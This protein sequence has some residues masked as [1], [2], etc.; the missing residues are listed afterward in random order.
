MFLF[1]LMFE[2]VNENVFV[3]VNFNFNALECKKSFNFNLN[4]TNTNVEIYTNVSSNGDAYVKAYVHDNGYVTFQVNVVLCN[5]YVN[6]SL[7]I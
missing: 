7:K 5:S 2:N 1:M 4:F 3:N 6:F